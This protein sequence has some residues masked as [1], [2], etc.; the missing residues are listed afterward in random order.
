MKSYLFLSEKQ[1]EDYIETCLSYD[2]L[3]RDGIG[4]SEI[5][6]ESL[7]PRQQY[8][9]FKHDATNVYRQV[10]LGSGY[11]FCDLIC[12]HTYRVSDHSEDLSQFKYYA[13]CVVVEIKN[14]D[15]RAADINQVLRYYKAIQ[16]LGI[17][18][19]VVPCIIG[20][21]FNNMSYL[22]DAIPDLYCYALQED[23]HELERTFVLHD[24]KDVRKDIVSISSFNKSLGDKKI[25]KHQNT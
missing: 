10:F 24:L 15:L 25:Q 12:V 4:L 18:S 16:S 13:V 11:G 22:I 3:F 1:F 21:G 5:T 6:H 9:F 14:K 17:F 20:Y 7:A 2:G 23:I 19:R 8:K